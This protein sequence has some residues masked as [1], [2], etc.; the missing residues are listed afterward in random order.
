[1]RD[2]YTTLIL[3]VV[4]I[5]FTIVRFNLLEFFKSYFV[6]VIDF[7]SIVEFRTN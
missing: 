5:L 7:L 1:M 6:I 4:I 3:H 2:Q